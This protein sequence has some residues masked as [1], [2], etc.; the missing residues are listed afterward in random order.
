[1]KTLGRAGVFVPPLPHPPRYYQAIVFFGVLN[2]LGKNMRL[3][4]LMLSV[5]TVNFI[6]LSGGGREGSCTS[7]GR[8]MTH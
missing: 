3:R 6:F 1:M 7:A 2:L 4:K 5:R 8:S